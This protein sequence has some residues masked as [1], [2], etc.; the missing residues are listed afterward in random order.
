MTKLSGTAHKGKNPCISISGRPLTVALWREGV[1]VYTSFKATHRDRDQ[2]PAATEKEITVGY[3]NWEK[4][5]SCTL[6]E[7]KKSYCILAGGC[8][9]VLK[10]INSYG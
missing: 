2:F 9:C 7:Q 3:R 10:C 1:R 8:P 4:A 6:V 5:T